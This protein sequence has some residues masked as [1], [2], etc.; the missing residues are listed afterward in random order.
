MMKRTFT[1]IAL[2]AL[3]G[4]R[5]SAQLANGS[6][7]PDFT[8][9]DIEGNTWHLYELLDQGKTVVLDVSA[10]WCG[11]CWAYH[12]TGALEELYAQ[13]GP[14]G[15]NEVMVLFIEGDP[16]TTMADLLGQTSASQGNWVG[17]TPYPILDNATIA[18]AYEITYFP[19]IYHICPNRIVNEIGQ[20][21]TDVLYAARGECLFASGNNNGGILRYD[22]FNGAFC[23]EVSFAP[24]VKFQNLGT[25][26]MTSA[27][28]ELLVD[29]NLVES[30]DWA[31]DEPTYGIVDVTFSEITLTQD[32]QV[33]VHI[34]SVNGSQDEDNV[35]DAIIIDINRAPA[36]DQNYARVEVRTDNYGVETYWEFV[37]GNGNALA[38][39]GNSGIF[40][41]DV[42]AGSYGNNTTYTKNV[43]LPADGCYDLVVYDYYGDGMCCQYGNGYYKLIAQN[44]DVLVEGGAFNAAS[45]NNPVEVS[46]AGIVNNSA[47]IVSYAGESG[48]FCNTLTY[49]PTLLIQNTGANEIT[50]AVI[51]IHDGAT[52]LQTFT[53]TGNLIA[54]DYASVDLAEVTVTDDAEL[55]FAITQVNSEADAFDEDN[56]TVAAFNKTD[57]GTNEQVLTFELKTDNYGYETYWQ[58]T[59]DAG[60]VL[61]SGG[62]TLVGPDGGGAG[63]AGPTNPGA[64]GNN[65][66]VSTQVTLPADDCYNVLVVDDYGDGMCCQYGSGYYRLKEANGTILISGGQFAGDESTPFGYEAVTSVPELTEVNQLNL[67]PN[68]VSND[69]MLQFDLTESMPLNIAVYNT[70][71]QKVGTVAADNFNAGHHTVRFD[72]SALAAGMYYVTFQSDE[73]RL[74]KKFT[75][76]R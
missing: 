39:G 2:L 31:G 38:T 6:I 17:T 25:I 29:G 16:T 33:E 35:N 68:P 22:G 11:P 59:N 40:T 24:A 14:E 5:L 72:A 54:G 10:T 62:N 12:N 46:G 32:A 57:V 50:S 49:T 15:T 1:L 74:S 28:L 37:D 63:V 18:D 20:V 45:V 27:V 30:L 53:W 42:A 64:Y 13:Y 34:A 44:G 19:T 8:A 41:G 26:N 9:T 43:L 73:K 61:A 67:F 75:V 76:S 71:G 65:T 52:L 4:A 69:L 66:V 58:I 36:Y 48:T 55:T 56:T 3:F 7:A 70:L 47:R 60:T 21:G 51:E 23:Q